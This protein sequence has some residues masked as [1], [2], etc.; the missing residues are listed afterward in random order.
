[1]FYFNRN[2]ILK[3]INTGHLHCVYI[4]E[5]KVETDAIHGNLP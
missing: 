5:E 2:I 3:L 1:M 4:K